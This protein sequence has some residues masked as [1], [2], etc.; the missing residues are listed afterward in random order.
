MLNE[1]IVS[2]ERAPESG[3]LKGDDLRSRARSTLGATLEETLGVANASF[4]AG[5]G[6]PVI[7][8]LQGSRVYVSVNGLGSHDV[9]TIS[10]DHAIPIEPLLAN[11]IRVWRGPA[12]IVFGGSALGGAVEIDDGRIP[13]AP[14]GDGRSRMLDVRYQSTL[15]EYVG[16]GAVDQ[17]LG[18]WV[19]HAG[20]FLRDRGTLSIPG[21][22]LDE[23]A[24]REQFSLLE[25]HNTD[26][27]VANAAARNYG[28]S[29]GT[30]LIRDWGLAGIAVTQNRYNY[31]I[32]PGGHPPHSHGVPAP[33]TPPADTSEEVRIDLA[34]SRLDWRLNLDQP[35]RLLDRVELRGAIVDYT[36]DELER[37][38][39]ATTF[40]NEVRELRLDLTQTTTPH[41]TTLAG[42]A[43]VDRD[44]AATGAEEFVPP[45]GVR[46]YNVFVLGQWQND[47]REAEVGWRWET[48]TTELK[49]E[50]RLI[51]G[52]DV[53]LPPSMK[54][55]TVS[56]SGG[57]TQHF[58]ERFSIR[59]SAQRA[60]RAPEVQEMLALG[61]HLAT[62]SFDVGNLGLTLETATSVELAF[63]AR[64]H[65]AHLELTLFGN[66][67]RDFIYQESQ[68]YFYDLDEALFRVRCV[69]L[70]ECLPVLGYKQQDAQFYGAE[71]L[72][73]IPITLPS[74]L[75]ELD[76][77]GDLSRGEFIAEGAGD[78]PRQPAPRL[79]AELRLAQ[80]RWTARLRW[81][82]ALDQQHAGLNETPTRG[83]DLVNLSAEREV[84]A[85]AVTLLG[86]VAV[87]N[88]L[89]SE[90]RNAVS[91]LRSF[92]P[93]PGRGVEVGVRLSY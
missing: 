27:E 82:H 83:Y 18:A 61:P 66:R 92:A 23:P 59:L 12:A 28:G 36:H 42:F 26:G 62:R 81:T 8:G 87:R 24:I 46:S 31:G 10:P 67:I 85:G 17:A 90:I 68:G 56:F 19:V 45:V 43:F 21:L 73:H 3:E 2:G 47:R 30:S 1:V 20:G 72:L 15:Q 16:A 41:F 6:L 14:P 40:D 75:L 11:R 71:A 77:F 13:L 65:R 93:E 9:S 76:L 88:L 39:P 22:A 44:F 29:L 52:L 32:P 70:E 48:H 37:G 69:R 33:G 84:K 25:L 49:K 63:D 7:R 79:G 55:E 38:T 34:Q 74:L 60:Q 64:V 89:D 57:I 4:G 53:L 86:H 54:Y 5:V 91:F 58:S 35:F 80:G 51:G 50:N 78:V